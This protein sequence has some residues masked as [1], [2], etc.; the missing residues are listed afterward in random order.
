MYGWSTDGETLASLYASI[1]AID[2]EKDDFCI[3]DTF[4][5]Q[6]SN[7]AISALYC[8]RQIKAKLVPLRRYVIDRQ[9][10]LNLQLK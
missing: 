4:N 5:D 8:H 10:A 2:W 3:F 6:V 1:K 9:A 7:A